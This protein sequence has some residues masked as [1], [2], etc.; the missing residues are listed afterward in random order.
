MPGGIRTRTVAVIPARAAERYP[1]LWRALEEAYPVRFVHRR[2]GDLTPA[3]AAIVFPGDRAPE[4]FHGPCLELHAEP[5]HRPGA[6]LQVELCTSDA[7]D[8]PLRGQTLAEHDRGAPVP[9]GGVDGWQVLATAEG[10]PI[11]ARR[12]AAAEG[13]RVAAA[14]V[15]R[16]LGER[17]YLRD[18]L[19]AGRFWSLLPL[20]Q[21]MRR[22]TG[23]APPRSAPLQ[24]CIVIDDPNVHR[25]AYGYV[26]FPDLAEDARNCG[27]HVAVA[28]IPLDLLAPGHRAA[29]VF[30]E[31]GSHLSL[32]VHGNDH[33]HR[34][35]DR[36]RNADEADRIVRSATERVAR[37]E[38]RVGIRVERVMC[39]PHGACGAHM[40][41]T[42]FR[43]GFLGLAA[44]RPFPW[45]S[46]SDHRHWRLGGW[47]PA[48]LTGGGLPVLPR[49]PINRSLDDLVFRAYLGQ[50]LIVYCHHGDLRDGLDPLREMAAKAAELGD[51]RWSSLA[52]ITRRNAVSDERDGVAAVTLHSRDVRIPGLRP[53]VVR[54]DV[55]RV[56]GGG[57]VLHLVVN[58]VSVEAPADRSGAYSVTTAVRPDGRGLHVRIAAPAG[59]RRPVSRT[60]WLPRPWPIVRRVLTE[61]R[62]RALPVLAGR[63][64]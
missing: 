59:G 52:S 34:E 55:P 23:D 30:R 47:L 3:D 45:D 8:R 29:G 64:R 42:L 32:A 56:A 1:E 2:A 5:P 18:H 21:F 49:H 51:V 35:L 44:S 22:V 31:S 36:P 48:Q 57:D 13:E 14:A 43:H 38:R 63:A 46:F 4:R 53:P 37:F 6:T 9:L 60:D 58:G 39:P 62:D 7:L 25:P 40:L 17:E 15:P 12:A 50:P 27:Y 28:T 33:V 41:R 19:T 61:S 10:S 26:N 24:A 54:I 16:E 20:V 11:W